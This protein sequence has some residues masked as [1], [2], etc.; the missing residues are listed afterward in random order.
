[1]LLVITLLA[2]TFVTIDATGGGAFD[3]VRNTASDVVSP[4]AG[5]VEWVTTPFRNAWAGVTGYEDLQVE[6]ER[7]RSELDD[8]EGREITEANAAEQLERLQQQLN[9]G[10]VEEIPTQV[11]RVTSGD[12]NNFE[13]HRVEIDKGRDAGLEVGMPV[14]T[15][16]GLVGRIERVSADR[17]VV[18]L[19]TD[20]TFVIGVRLADTQVLGVGH[21]SGAGA[22]FVVDRG[23]ELS[24][25]VAEGEFVLTSGLDR[26]VMPPDVPV[27]SVQQVVPDES[28]QTLVLRVRFSARLS[29]LDVVQV[30]KWTPPA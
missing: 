15:R 5:A 16:G 3:P 6:N 22:P 28:S 20:P 11:A 30:M 24:D 4:L 21:G 26:S 7:L 14:V 10:F 12:R 27:G 2:I 13:D 19:A 17:S 29:E 8:L 18:Q 25:E 1:V 9:I 23:P